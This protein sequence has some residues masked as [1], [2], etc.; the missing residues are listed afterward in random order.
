MRTYSGSFEHDVARDDD[1]Q[2]LLPQRRVVRGELLVPADELVQARVVGE[3]LE[4]H[5][6]GRAL[7]LEHRLGDLASPDTRQVEHC[8]RGTRHGS[9]SRHVRKR[10]GR[11][12]SGR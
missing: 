6:L 11:S 8:L 2:T 5:A 9:G 7:D 1:E 3:R 12:P 10:R 4:R